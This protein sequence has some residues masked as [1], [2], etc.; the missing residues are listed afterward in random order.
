ME[1][2][3]RAQIAALEAELADAARRAEERELSARS[4]QERAEE[5]A[6]QLAASEAARDEMDGRPCS[7]PMKPKMTE[8]K[9]AGTRVT[10]K[11]MRQPSH[12][13]TTDPGTRGM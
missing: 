4:A 9:A 11:G 2:E 1:R 8:R 13:R 3:L 12:H 6:R 7:R 5:L 10:S